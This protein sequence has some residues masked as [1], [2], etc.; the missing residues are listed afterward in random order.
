LQNDPEPLRMNK[1]ATMPARPRNYPN[2][3]G[4]ITGGPLL[5]LGLLQ[6]AAACRPGTVAAGRSLE[7][8]AFLQNAADAEIDAVVRIIPPERDLADKPGRFSSP[9]NKPVRIGLLPGEVGYARL[10]LLVGHQATP[11]EA[12]SV[13]LEVTVEMRGRSATRVRDEGGGGDFDPAD[14]DDLRRPLLHDVQGLRCATDSE[15]SRRGGL[16][17]VGAGRALL[18]APFSVTPA[19]IA[20]LPGDL[21]ADYVRLWTKEDYRDDAWIIAKAR[22]LADSLLPHMNRL[23]AFF[24][25]VKYTQTCFEGAGYRLYAGEAVLIAKLVCLVLEMG[26]SMT[27]AGRR[28][29]VQPGWY[30]QL[31]RALV[32]RPA[33]A[34]PA[35]VEGLVT[36]ALYFDL[37]RDAAMLGFSMVSTITREDFGDEDEQAAFVDRLID[38]LVTGGTAGPP[39]DV[40]RVYLP[41]VLGG[42]VANTRLSMPQ[43]NP[44]E[45]VTLLQ[46]ALQKRDGERD[47]RTEM[48]FMMAA[49]LIVRALAT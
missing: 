10:P 40:S 8:L 7:A 25:L 37:L 16:L 21:K 46:R 6:I 42:L 27:L 41:L 34:A 18:R 1:G 2:I 39:L 48:V 5:N 20:G 38:S 9:V 4:A 22:P 15:E 36:E 45:T 28:E 33:L 11:G 17:G 3:L 44:T 13:G 35:H 24:P 12:Y 43:E 26:T 32:R 31:C 29:P 30:A 23:R 19:V 47:A 49:D 14:L